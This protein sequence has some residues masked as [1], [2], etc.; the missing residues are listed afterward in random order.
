[1]SKYNL[2]SC[3]PNLVLAFLTL[4]ST[5]ISESVYSDARS[6]KFLPLELTIV[7]LTPVVRMSKSFSFSNKSL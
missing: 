6:V 1:M 3:V 4:D 2:A 5:I 7:A